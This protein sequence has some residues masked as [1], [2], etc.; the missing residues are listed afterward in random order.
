MPTAELLDNGSFHTMKINRSMVD[1]VIEAP[2][3]AHFTNCQ[4][5]YERDEAFQKEYAKAA[6]DPDTLGGVRRPPTSPA[7][8]PTTSR[9]CATDERHDLHRH[10]HRDGDAT[11]A[12]ICVAALADAFAG[13][14][15]IFASGMGTIPM[16]GARLARATSEPDLLISDGEAFFVGQ[17]HWPSAA[18][19]RRS[20]A[21][22]RSAA[23]STRSGAG[24][25]T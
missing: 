24:A 6:A 8:R 12:E 19:T 13:D 2:N 7:P 20:R 5:D 21:G 10:R 4:P 22:C 11:L 25:A 16:L 3:G 15:E 17:R 1:G 18:P 23:C 9:R 14:G